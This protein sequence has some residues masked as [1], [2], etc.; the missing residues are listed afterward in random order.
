MTAYKDRKSYLQLLRLIAAVVEE[1]KRDYEEAYDVLLTGQTDSGEPPAERPDKT[2]NDCERFF[3]VMYGE[4]AAHNLCLELRC[5][6]AGRL[7]EK[8]PR[9]VRRH[10]RVYYSAKL[11]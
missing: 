5:S 10:T 3:T 1:A 4:D 8:T 9:L 2:I 7:L 11:S 6:S